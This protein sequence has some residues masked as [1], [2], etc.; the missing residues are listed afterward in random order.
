MQATCHTSSRHV[1]PVGLCKWSAWYSFINYFHTKREPSLFI[2]LTIPD[3]SCSYPILWSTEDRNVSTWP[4]QKLGKLSA[5]T[6]PYCFLVFHHQVTD[7]ESRNPYDSEKARTKASEGSGRQE[8]EP[9]LSE[10]MPWHQAAACSGL[11]VIAMIVLQVE[12]SS[13]LEMGIWTYWS[14]TS[15]LQ[16]VQE[17]VLH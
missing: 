2:T 17:S 11:L 3:S 14:Y 8:R 9:W 1:I 16:L 12:L 5:S 6:S 15:K 7:S 10:L 4:S 13:L